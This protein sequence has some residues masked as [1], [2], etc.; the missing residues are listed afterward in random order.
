MLERY[1]T[2]LVPY[3]TLPLRLVVGI[4]FLL[5]GWPKLVNPNRFINIVTNA[6]FPSP[7]LLAWIPIIMEPLGGILL[8]IGLGTRWVGLYF[9]IE[10]AITTLSSKV[11]RGTPF[12]Q[13]GGAPGAG[14][15]LDLLLLAG[16]LVLLI[17]GSGQIS[18]E[19]NLLRREL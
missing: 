15:E 14:Y 2:R 10:M 4:A 18:L 3:A 8:I 13:G 7:E 1:T 5:H 19:R 6:G 11:M 17:L 16:A 12:I 9:A